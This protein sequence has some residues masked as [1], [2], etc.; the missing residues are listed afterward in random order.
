MSTEHTILRDEATG[1]VIDLGSAD[2]TLVDMSAALDAMAALEAGSIAN[3][4]EQR[5]VGH[6]WLRSP[7]LA[8]L[9]AEQIVACWDQIEALADQPTTDVLLIG[10]GGSAL[11]PEL[12]VDALAAQPER[13][14]LLDSTDP[15]G[16][17]RTLSRVDPAKTTVIVA[18]KSGRTVETLTGLQAAQAHWARSGQA[19]GPSAIAITTEGSPLAELAAD[20]QAIVPVWEWVGGRTSISSAVGLLPMALM[21]IDHRAFL[22]GAAAMDRWSRQPD[23]P[24]AALAAIWHSEDKPSWVFLP[25][26]DRLRHLGRYIQ[27]LVMESLGKSH[28]R[29]GQ[30]VHHGRTV[31]GNKGSADQ[32]ALVQQLRDGPNDVLVH[33][34]DVAARS[35]PTPLLLVAADTQLSLLQGTRSSLDK[36]SRPTL[37]LTLP[38]CSAG[39][40]GAL[41]ALLER[42]VGLYAE[43][44][45]IN[46]YHQPGVE[47]GKHASTALIT[48]LAAIQSALSGTPKTAHE[49]AVALEIPTQTAWRLCQHLSTTDRAR[50]TRGSTASEDRFSRID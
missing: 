47:A 12:L 42:A 34:V 41:V 39:S 28:T 7:Q 3:P 8:P 22:A 20:W 9:G 38:N 50:C 19:F 31:F 23:G 14:H 11:G 13:F 32:H 2:L 24:A 5:Q 40:L 6:Y 29:S 27:Q 25:Y 43:L 26:A 44:R 10:I 33:F 35:T 30:A 17:A 46:A 18:S 49:I 36:A 48:E 4:D 37:Q 16:I 45:D 21:G 1:L 15:D